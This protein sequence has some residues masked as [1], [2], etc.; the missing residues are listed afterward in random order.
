MS[1]LKLI[2]N[3]PGVFTVFIQCLV[4][5][6]MCFCLNSDLKNVYKFW[7]NEYSSAILAATKIYEI[8]LVNPSAVHC[9]SNMMNQYVIITV[10]E[11]RL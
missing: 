7:Y 5:E 8:A 4:P 1:V 11:Y 2:D 3:E 10:Y 9:E 6:V